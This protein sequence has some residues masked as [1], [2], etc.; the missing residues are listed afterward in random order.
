MVPNSLPT[1]PLAMERKVGD[2]ENFRARID[3]NEAKTP[4]DD[5]GI[6]EDTL[7]SRGLGIGDD[8]EVLGTPTD[9]KIPDG[10]ADDIGLVAIFP[11]SLDDA[12]GVWVQAP[13]FYMMFL[14]S[15]NDGLCNDMA[16]FCSTVAN[17]QR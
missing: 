4:S 2:F 10:P 16:V 3:M 14:L 12:E 7:D 13:F 9:Q 11:Q 1:V 5:P 8:V 15:I 6:A 17:E